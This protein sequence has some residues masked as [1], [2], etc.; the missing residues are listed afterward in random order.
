M[1]TAI[2]VAAGPSVADLVSGIQRAFLVDAVLGL[3]GTVV[4]V[5]R[6]G[7]RP[8]GHGEGPE[9]RFGHHRLMPN[10]GV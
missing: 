10:R 5:T 6:V 1:N 4:T 9:R 7:A 8:P 3:L 2:V